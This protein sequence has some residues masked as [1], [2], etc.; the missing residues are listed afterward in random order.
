MAETAQTKIVVPGAHAM[1]S[2]LGQRDELLAIIERAFRSDIL[3]RGNEI[4]VTGEPTEVALAVR[5]LRS[6][7]RCSSVATC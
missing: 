2:L 7:S 3:V 4:T 1:V 5:L 6:S